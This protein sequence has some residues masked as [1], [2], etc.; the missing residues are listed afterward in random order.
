MEEN[1]HLTSLPDC[2]TLR[3]TPVPSKT[4]RKGTKGRQNFS[5]E[6]KIALTQ[7]VGNI[8]PIGP[9]E[10][11][12][13][14]DSYNFY[15]T[16]HRRQKRETPS[17][18]K[19]FFEVLN[20]KP[21]TGSGERSH[22]VELALIASQRINS[23]TFA[24]NSSSLMDEDI[25]EDN[26]E[27]HFTNEDSQLSDCDRDDTGENFSNNSAASI[28][29]KTVTSTSSNTETIDSS[30][31]NQTTLASSAIELE[32]NQDQNENVHWKATD[33]VQNKNKNKNS[34]HKQS[35]FS[36]SPLS[37][38]PKMNVNR[39][40]HGIP[41]Q[42]AEKSELAKSI[43]YLAD[44]TLKLHKSRQN[45]GN[46]NTSTNSSTSNQNL[47][48]DMSCLTQTMMQLA[49]SQKQQHE[50]QLNIMSSIA[51]TMKDLSNKFSSTYTN[52][53]KGAINSEV[54][55]FDSHVEQQ[56][57]K[58]KEGEH[59]YEEEE[60]EEEED[61][62]DGQNEKDKGEKAKRRSKRHRTKRNKYY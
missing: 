48:N 41:N 33:V 18:R 42:K 23:R 35:I 30:Q 55:H 27:D 56:Q 59:K 20:T 60:E 15:A 52:T 57:Q 2:S 44:T 12:N 3:N 4:Q 22:E 34:Q 38:I 25:S 54:I 9:D 8:A 5:K 6:D 28:Q 1:T 14:R 16:R 17:L 46:S 61:V 21:P 40:K 58:R 37:K 43:Y 24:G 49:E 26:S 11:R 29:S 10:W 31:N 47:Q 53:S 7:L 51:E 50:Q 45:I 36:L 62:V 19:K 32:F 39:Q 13:L